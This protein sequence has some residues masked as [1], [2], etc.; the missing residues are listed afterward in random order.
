[1]SF[2]R[3][4]PCAQC[5]WLTANHGKRNGEG[6]YSKANRRRLWTGIRRGD[7]PGMSCHPTDTRMEFPE[8]IPGPSEGTE[9]KACAGWL[10]L[11]QIELKA[12]EMMGKRYHDPAEIWRAYVADAKNRGV[13][14]MTRAGL[15]NF[16]GLLMPKPLGLAD[17]DD[18]MPDYILDESVNHTLV[19]IGA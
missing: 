16:A 4:E 3:K 19:S 1:M 9:M 10:I 8:H 11:A 18:P 13:Q 6:W 5:P 2:Y 15:L 7:A 14:P 12:Y 17:P